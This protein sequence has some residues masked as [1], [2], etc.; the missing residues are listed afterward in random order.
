MKKTLV[1]TILGVVACATTFAQGSISFN[2]YNTAAGQVTYAPG[3]G[4]SPGTG[5]NSTF[6]AALYYALGTPVIPADPT[7]FADPTTLG[8]TLLGGNTGKTP[9]YPSQ[10]VVNGAGAGYFLG[11]AVQ[12]PDYVSGPITFMVVA[13]NG[14]NYASSLVRG[15][16]AA[17][18][19]ASLATGAQP[20]QN[21][22]GLQDFQVYLVP[23]P[24]S[25][26]LAGLGLAGLLIFR[27]R[28]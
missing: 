2:N 16:S 23:E 4:G 8:L 18:V 27:R 6:T 3:S 28:K 5:V 21:F 19:E 20:V 13:Y 10:F 1:A 25:F 12:I 22:T 24:S 14:A 26:A 15:H 11:P 17:F 9:P 7:G